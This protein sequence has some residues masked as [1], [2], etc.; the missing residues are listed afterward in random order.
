MDRVISWIR[1]PL[2]WLWLAISVL[3]LLVVASRLRRAQSA[4]E[5]SQRRLRDLEGEDRAERKADIE[6][7]IQSHRRAQERAE[8]ARRA[9]E[10]KIDDLARTDPTLGDLIDRWNSDRLRDEHES[11][12]V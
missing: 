9:A 10:G 6:D 4:A 3:A 8:A 11:G 2:R 5:A 1:A 12:S 7:S